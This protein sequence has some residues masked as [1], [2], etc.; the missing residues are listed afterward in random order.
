MF[1]LLTNLKKKKR[2]RR[3]ERRKKEMK[4]TLLNWGGGGWG[5]GGTTFLKVILMIICR[6]VQNQLLYQGSLSGYTNNSIHDIPQLTSE[7]AREFM[8][9]LL[10]CWTA[11]LVARVWLLD[12]AGWGTFSVFPSPCWLSCQCL[13]CI[14]VCTMHQYF[15]RTVKITCPPF[16][17]R[18]PKG[19]WHGL[20]VV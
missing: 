9:D 2:W 3:K 7:E 13:S 10:T 4:P 19:S 16:L 18:R 1:D 6:K 14:C 11:N 12:V 8:E 5:G 17:K 20:V 15:F